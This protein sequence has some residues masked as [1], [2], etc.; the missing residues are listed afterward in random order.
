MVTYLGAKV[1]QARKKYGVKYPLMY[2]SKE[3]M[4]NCYQR[5]HQNTLEQIPYFLLFLLLGGIQHPGVCI[6]CGLIWIVSRLSY[7]FGY[8]TGD[9]EKR[10]KGVYGYIGLFG[11]IAATISFALHLLQWI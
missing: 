11:L 6:V 8:Y 4:F 9:P 3:P 2:D 10:L 1:G 7:A 5:A